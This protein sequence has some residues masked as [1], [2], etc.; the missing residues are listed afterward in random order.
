MD[1]DLDPERLSKRV[2]GERVERYHGEE[3]EREKEGPVTSPGRITRA[4]VE[5]GGVYIVS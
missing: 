3:E 1:R 4:I 5:E 2:W